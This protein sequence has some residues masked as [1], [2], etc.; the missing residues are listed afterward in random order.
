MAH[1]PAATE[2]LPALSS[3]SVQVMAPTL[4]AAMAPAAVPSATLR[5]SGHLG[6]ILG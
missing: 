6:A 2:A 5:R 3:A 4:R 1:S